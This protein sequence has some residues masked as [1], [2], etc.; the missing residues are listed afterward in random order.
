MMVV[1]GD[2]LEPNLQFKKIK[3]NFQAQYL[4][5]AILHHQNLLN[6]FVL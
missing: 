1:N 5:E 6:H 4:T 2:G 3:L